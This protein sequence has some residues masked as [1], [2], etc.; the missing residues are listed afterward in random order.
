MSKVKEQENI[1]EIC[2][3]I[4]TEAIHMNFL[5]RFSQLLTEAED[6]L[7]EE[8][9]QE[10]EMRYEDDIKELCGQI[11]FYSGNVRSLIVK[12]K[13]NCE[14]L[15]RAKQQLDELEQQI[16]AEQTF[17]YEAQKAAALGGVK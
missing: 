7:D 6:A 12:L 15:E 17:E 13:E 2:E 4:T 14:E 1:E 3:D 16:I 11:E 10:V 5:E 8:I 9:V